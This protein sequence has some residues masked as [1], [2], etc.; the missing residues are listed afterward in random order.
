M[1]ATKL[2]HS[3]ENCYSIDLRDSA[4]QKSIR[5]RQLHVVADTL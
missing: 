1:S 4:G 5:V 2:P 3:L